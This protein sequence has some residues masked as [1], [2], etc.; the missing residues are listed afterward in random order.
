MSHATTQT[1]RQNPVGRPR[2]LPERTINQGFN[3][4]ESQSEMVTR[5]APRYGGK[6]AVLRAALELL[7]QVEQAQTETP[8]ARTTGV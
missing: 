7:A 6:S 2:I 4:L 5:L 8:M 3:L 1:P